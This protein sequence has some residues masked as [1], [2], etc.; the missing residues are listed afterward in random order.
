MEFCHYPLQFG[1]MVKLRHLHISY[2]FNINNAE[3]LVEDSSKLYD[4]RTL[5]TPFFS[6]VKDA[7]FVLRKTPN[8]QEL[9]LD[10][11][12]VGNGQFPVLDFPTRLETLHIYHPRNQVGVPYPYPVCISTSNLK[13]L[14]V[15]RFRLGLQL[16][17]LK[18]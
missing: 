8:I 10:F 14:T 12:G 7:E 16:K 18:L 11:K 2:S 1:K 17:V 6:C 3:E 5:S 4:L 15:T 13:E 9:K